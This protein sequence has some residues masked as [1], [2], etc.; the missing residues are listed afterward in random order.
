MLDPFG[1]S[2]KTIMACEKAGRQ[3]RV[4]QLDPKYCDVIFRPCE[5]FTGALARGADMGRAFG[6]AAAN[7][8]MPTEQRLAE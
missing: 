5:Q 1:G 7:S 4:L 3:A 8:S 2:G 6:Q